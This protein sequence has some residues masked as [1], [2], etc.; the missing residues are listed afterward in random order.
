MRLN[1]TYKYLYVLAV[2]FLMF[3]CSPDSNC[4]TG[5][6][7]ISYDDC[8]SN[9]DCQEGWYC[10]E[11]AKKC[12]ENLCVHKSDFD[13]GNGKCV[14]DGYGTRSCECDIGYS[15]GTGSYCLLKCNSYTDCID[16]QV[17]SRDYPICSDTINGGVCN[18]AVCH[19][20]DSCPIGV[21]ENS[22]CVQ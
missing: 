3:N 21:C 8:S 15:S 10:N 12:Y 4:A 2:I 22:R 13:C 11:S 20:D 14:I 17:N 6:T 7:C 5:N 16:Y 9:S 18:L 1:Y 19:G